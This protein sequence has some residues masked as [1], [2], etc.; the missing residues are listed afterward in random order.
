MEPSEYSGDNQS[1]EN[2]EWD[3]QPPESEW[4]SKPE[5]TASWSEQ[6][7]WL[8]RN[9]QWPGGESNTDD[10]SQPDLS[11][12]CSGQLELGRLVGAKLLKSEGLDC[13]NKKKGGYQEK[14]SL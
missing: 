3:S 4:D 11:N 10:E 12:L 6:K 8:K 14:K 2:C 7:A 9:G 13:N 1:Q 5:S